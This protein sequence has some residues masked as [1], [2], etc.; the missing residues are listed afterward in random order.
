L[1]TDNVVLGP[2]NNN[3]ATP[4]HQL[5]RYADAEAHYK[6][7][8]AIWEKSPGPDHPD[9][10]TALF[11]LGSAYRLQSKFADAEISYRRGV[12]ITIQRSGR[13]NDA[14]GQALTGK[15][16]SEATRARRRFAEWIKVAWKQG[17]RESARLTELTRTTFQAV[18]SGQGSEAVASL[19]QMAVRLAKG[20]GALARLIRQRQDLAAEWEDKEKLLIQVRSDP[21][22]RR[23]AGGQQ[24]L[25]A[26][27]T[28]IDVRIGE[29][30][31]RLGKEFPDY[32]ALA[33]R[34]ASSI[35][36]AQAQFAANEVL[37]VFF[38]TEQAAPID[39]ETFVW[40]VTKTGVRWAR[41]SFGSRSLIEAVAA[42][43]CG[44]DR[45]AWDGEGGQRC[46]RVLP[47]A[48]NSAEIA[49]G[50]ALPFDLARAHAL[51]A[52]LFGAI[53]DLIK[54]KHF[55]IV[56][57]G[58][59]TAIPFHAL[60]TE[61]PTTSIPADAIGFAN[62][63]WL[64]RRHAITVLPSVGS[65]RSLRRFAK[66]SKATQPFVGFGNPLLV[67]PTGSDK[68]AWERQSCPKDPPERIRVARR[69]V[70]APLS[71]FFLGNLADVELVRGQHP[72][73]ETADELCAVARS[74]GA[75]QAAIHLGDKAT[76]K[77]ASCCP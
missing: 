53:E 19:A 54:D 32:S 16:E 42:L 25:S 45:A 39:E 21:Y 58:P 2:A 50:K 74:T 59:L 52:T 4:Y 15:V 76:E 1:D 65:L 34:E 40:A 55:L 37:I 63:A 17:E 72:L 48:P 10:G 8:L 44:L 51:Y 71:Q 61:K 12:E 38:D 62:V 5:G 57:S 64:A 18:Q 70:R 11:N 36:A 43:R 9:V 75:P 13:G 22:G 49:A 77:A 35:E 67:D 26:R 66:A 27:L 20:D 3:L 7:A 33:N 41:S 31:K 28:A 47:G 23:D 24:A 14:I 6:R 68:S 73:A 29:I 69:A 30:D 56:P 60:V 46:V